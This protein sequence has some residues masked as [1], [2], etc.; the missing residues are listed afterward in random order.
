MSEAGS[1]P[2][3]LVK[4]EEAG[5]ETGRP[6]ENEPNISLEETEREGRGEN[7]EQKKELIR[8]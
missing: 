2:A 8:K 4:K 3:G 1:V 7:E 5:S 6:P